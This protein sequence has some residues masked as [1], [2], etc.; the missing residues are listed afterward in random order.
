MT[1]LELITASMVDLGEAAQGETISAED[2]ASGLELLNDILTSLSNDRLY[3]PLITSFSGPF[4]AF[5][6]TYTLGPSGSLVTSVQPVV[7]QAGSVIVSGIS[8]S[9]DIIS[10]PAWNQ[11]QEDGLTGLLPLKVWPNATTPNL[12]LKF[13]PIPNSAQT[14]VLNFWGVL[15]NGSLLLSDTIALPPGYLRALRTVL[16][17]ELAPGYGREP[18]KALLAAKEDSHALVRN[19]ALLETMI[20]EGPNVSPS[21]GEPQRAG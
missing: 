3:I 4:V 19:R 13:W 5:T 10:A 16:A 7:L 14:V 21:R 9:L 12:T 6:Q 2:A 20:A 18:S 11:I 8:H 15:L 17:I 1:G